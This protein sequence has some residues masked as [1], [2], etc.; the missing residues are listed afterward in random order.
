MIDRLRLYLRGKGASALAA[1]AILVAVAFVRPAAPALAHQGGGNQPALFPLVFQL[2]D[3]RDDEEGSQNSQPT[4][5][6]RFSFTGTIESVNYADKTIRLLGP[7]GK[8]RIAITPTTAISIRGETGGI[9]DL[10]H[11]VHLTATGVM[12]H[13]VATALSITIK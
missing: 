6:S 10:R 8:L 7:S 3:E 11:G 5:E 4:P 12:H 1:A 9:S 2:L 13:G